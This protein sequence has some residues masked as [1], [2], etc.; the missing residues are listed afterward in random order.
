MSHEAAIN[1]TYK[2]LRAGYYWPSLFSDV[3]VLV[4]ACVEFQ[5]F[6]GKK[7]FLPL[8]LKPIKVETSF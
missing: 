7:K 2:I 5:V 8:H 3:N 4:R 1:N 6:G